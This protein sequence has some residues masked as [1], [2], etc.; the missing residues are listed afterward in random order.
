MCI[1]KN[2]YR[3]AAPLDI[4]EIDFKESVEHEEIKGNETEETE[5][6]GKNSF[7]EIENKLK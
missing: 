5:E 1:N 6:I 7:D 2:F 4:K 3:A